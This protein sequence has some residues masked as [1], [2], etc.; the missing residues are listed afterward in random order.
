LSRLFNPKLLTNCLRRPGK[1]RSAYRH[2][3]VGGSCS[4]ET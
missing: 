2:R 4:E 3:G 1:M